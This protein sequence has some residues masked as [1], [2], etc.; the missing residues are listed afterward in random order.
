MSANNSNQKCLE[1]LPE[2]QKPTIQKTSNFIISRPKACT[3]ND[4]E[5]TIL[6]IAHQFYKEVAREISTI[7]QINCFKRKVRKVHHNYII[8]KEIYQNDLSYYAFTL[9]PQLQINSQSSFLKYEHNGFKIYNAIPFRM[10][11]KINT[12]DK[13]FHSPFVDES[14]SFSEEFSKV[15]NVTTKIKISNAHLTVQQCEHV[16]FAPICNSPT[17]PKVYKYIGE[18]TYEKEQLNIPEILDE[19]SQYIVQNFLDLVHNGSSQKLQ[20]KVK[21]EDPVLFVTI[22]KAC[23]SGYVK[24]TTFW[25]D[26]IRLNRNALL[27]YPL[28]YSCTDVNGLT[29]DFF[30]KEKNSLTIV[31]S[32]IPPCSTLFKIIY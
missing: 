4:A 10:P 3:K 27:K 6:T 23:G 28:I 19:A 15:H 20:H 26:I 13:I 29:V 16:S 2:R 14:S 32:E 9:K 17:E 11:K 8:P 18:I 5:N 12:V 7:E 24:L 30:E 1:K 22:E 31:L 25:D 21:N